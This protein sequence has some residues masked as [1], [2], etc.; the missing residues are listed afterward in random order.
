[1][2]Y[3]WLDSPLPVAEEELG[4]G[5]IRRTELIGDVPV[6]VAVQDEALLDRILA[7]ARVRSP[8]ER[9]CAPKS[10][11]YSDN[12]PSWNGPRS[13][14]WI[15]AYTRNADRGVTPTYAALLGEESA[16][17]FLCTTEGVGLAA[18][19]EARRPVSDWIAL[20]VL[21]GEPAVPRD[22]WEHVVY[23]G[24]P[25]IDSYSS[26]N[27]RL[28]AE[29]IAT[30]AVGGIPAIVLAPVGVDLPPGLTWGPVR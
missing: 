12:P 9:G 30:W 6:T 1:V 7:T 19:Q 21:A 4:A 11:P 22:V 25:G 15:C 27:R 24:Y 2:P 13:G 28:T 3:V 17:S 5:W 29:D 18:C 16:D 8:I 10:R 20:Q 14:M 23:L 26:M